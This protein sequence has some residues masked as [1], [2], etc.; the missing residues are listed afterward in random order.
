MIRL[1]AACM[2][3]TLVLTARADPVPVD[4]SVSDA[5]PTLAVPLASLARLHA[6]CVGRLPVAGPIQV[7]IP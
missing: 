2:L 6:Q 7:G 5:A 3:L 1:I 4:H